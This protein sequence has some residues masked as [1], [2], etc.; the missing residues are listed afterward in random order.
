MGSNDLFPVL[1]SCLISDINRTCTR[2]K[3]YMYIHIYGL[4]YTFFWCLILCHD[5][6]V[7]W[8]WNE[9]ASYFG[10]VV[11]YC[12]SCLQLLTVNFCRETQNHFLF[13]THKGLFP[14]VMLINLCWVTFA[15]VTWFYDLKTALWLTDNPGNDFFNRMQISWAQDI[16][17]VCF[18]KYISS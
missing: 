1:P 7:L 14:L 17:W 9:T 15:S 3:N 13:L 12:F 18:F 11:L 5:F 4:P 2:N 8:Q 16:L 10:F 6:Q